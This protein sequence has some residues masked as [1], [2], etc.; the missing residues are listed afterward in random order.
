M[1]SE[2]AKKLKPSPTLALNARAQELAKTGKSVISLA[3]GEPD[4]DTFDHIKEAAKKATYKIY[5][6][7]LDMSVISVLNNY[8]SVAR[9]NVGHLHY[10]MKDTALATLQDTGQEIV[11][12][13]YTKSA[14]EINKNHMSFLFKLKVVT[15]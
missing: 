8:P 10:F 1:L 15:K 7:P 4:W 3:V 5:H 13:F 14:F 11:D 9:E 12:W 6:I 2:R